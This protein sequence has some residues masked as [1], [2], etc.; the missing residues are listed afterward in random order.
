[1]KQSFDNLEGGAHVNLSEVENPHV[2]ANLLLHYFRWLDQ[3]LLTFALYDKLLKI[4]EVCVAQKGCETSIDA[5]CDGKTHSHGREG[6]MINRLPC[7]CVTDLTRSVREV[8]CQLPKGNCIQMRLLFEFL[9]QLA[10][11]DVNDIT[12][13]GLSSIFAPYLCNAHSRAFMSIRHMEDL[14]ALR[15]VIQ[16]AIEKFDD[17]FKEPL[18]IVTDNVHDN[19]ALQPEKST[20]SGEIVGITESM[21]LL[22]VLLSATV[23]GLLFTHPKEGEYLSKSFSTGC[24]ITPQGDLG[25]RE[26]VSDDSVS[27]VDTN[28]AVIVGAS[29]RRQAVQA[30]RQLKASIKELEYKFADVHGHPPCSV[31]E[32]QQAGVHELAQKYRRCK[33]QIRDDAAASLQALVRGFRVRKHTAKA[34]K[35]GA[36][37]HD[38]RKSVTATKSISKISNQEL[39][40][41]LKDE[42]R[43]L[44][45][46]LKDYDKSFA[47]DHGRLPTK[48]EKEPIRWLYEQYNNVKARIQEEERNKTT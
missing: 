40:K 1:M 8:V 42:K 9:S 34:V 12:S 31:A 3:P 32:K 13:Q 38:P 29:K 36:V 28:S 11:T 45:Q 16:L 19:T 41:R 30:C 17:I 48:S 21:K 43:D 14:P 25:K 18:S 2:V 15:C 10:S 20:S 24:Y 23:N 5:D 46:K 35:T 26:L 6:Q 33:R 22:K 4:G 7:Q 47:Q 39:K 44:K 27:V 37:T